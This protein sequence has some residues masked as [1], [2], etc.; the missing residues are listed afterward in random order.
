MII[1]DNKVLSLQ[2]Y[3]SF[4]SIESASAI[5]G[6][7]SS[8]FWGLLKSSLGELSRKFPKESFIET[9]GFDSF[10]FTGIAGVIAITKNA[11]IEIIPKF[12]SDDNKNW[13][14]DFLHISLI[15]RTGHLFP[16]I[17]M[18]TAP[19]KNADLYEI[20]GEAWL[21][22]FES[23]SRYLL[24]SYIKTCWT[25]FQ[26][27]GEVEDEDLI[28]PTFEGFKQ[29]GLKL[30]KSNK[31]NELLRGASKILKS[32]ISNPNNIARLERALGTLNLALKD[33]QLIKKN[34][35][36]LGR[37]KRWIPILELSEIILANLSLG[38]SQYG[39]S[40][41]PGYILQTHQAWEK[42]IF[43]ALKKAYPQN[44]VFKKNYLLGVRE[45]NQSKIQEM[46]TTPDVSISDESGII[47]I[48]DAKYKEVRDT[49]TNSSKVV[50]SATDIYES[51][52]FSKAVNIKKI[53][54]IY[55][56]KQKLNYDPIINQPL[57][58]FTSD[59]NFVVGLSV[60]VDGFANKDGLNI[61]TKNLK[62]LLDNF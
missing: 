57:E 19:S 48:L 9:K 60:G 5:L 44:K 61:L 55:P 21:N 33:E 26:I 36:S 14:D 51:L 56:N 43:I 39:N 12:L 1:K 18:L 17:R 32:R 47:F 29:K 38:F 13:R 6:I 15:S 11:K 53:Y 59:G 37:D 35:E 8:L 52:A 46:L 10:R 31:Y 54:L 62:T 49:F 4:I 28:F 30:S 58:T 3:G 41:I 42:L 27:D 34:R 45:S 22:L 50:I 2:E 25:D 16:E 40:I 7:K 20:I 24:K 23:N